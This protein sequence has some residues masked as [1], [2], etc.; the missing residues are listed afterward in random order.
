MGDMS[1][2]TQGVQALN[3]VVDEIFQTLEEVRNMF[4]KWDKSYHMEFINKVMY[5]NALRERLYKLGYADDFVETVVKIAYH[6]VFSKEEIRAFAGKR[7][8]KM[9]CVK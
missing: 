1:N 5:L 7:L 9:V 8:Y 2:A 6:N 3:V 4:S